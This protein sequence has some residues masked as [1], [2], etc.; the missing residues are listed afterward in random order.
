MYRIL[1]PLGGTAVNGQSGQIAKIGKR[2][3]SGDTAIYNACR[4]AVGVRYKSKINEALM[5]I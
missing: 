5:G 1:Q 4:G 3:M 2:V